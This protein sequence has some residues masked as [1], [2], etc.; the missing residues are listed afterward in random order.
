MKATTLDGTNLT[1]DAVINVKIATRGDLNVDGEVDVKDVVGMINYIM[2]TPDDDFDDTLADM[3]EDGAINIGDLIMELRAVL[4]LSSVSHSRAMI[5]ESLDGTLT[6]SESNKHID[7][8][9]ETTTGYTAFQM[10]VSVPEGVYIDNVELYGVK[11]NTHKILW[12]LVDDNKYILL[13]YSMD[14]STLDIEDN[15]LLNISLNGGTDGKV[16]ISNIKFVTP[17]GKMNSLSDVTIG[18]TTGI[19]TITENELEDSDVYNV[20]GVKVSNDKK[21]LKNLKKGVYIINGKKQVVK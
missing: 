17:S 8:N 7:V 11:A 3:N 20:I 6:V 16:E 21:A 9:L 14:N 18:Y 19:R 15:N 4:G 12:N 1:A 13:G 5:Q 10:E 2:G